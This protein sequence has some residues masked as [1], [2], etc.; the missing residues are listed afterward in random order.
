MKATIGSWLFVAFHACFVFPAH[1]QTVPALQFREGSVLVTG[2]GSTTIPDEQ[3]KDLLR[4]FTHEAFVKRMNQPVAGTYT[5]LGDSLTFTPDFNFAAGETYHA[6]FG[7]LELSF[8]IPKPKTEPTII[9]AVHPQAEVLPENMLRMYIT[10][11]NAMM[12]GEAYEHITLFRENGTPVEKAF[13]IID[14]ELWDAERKRFTLLF[15]PGRVKRGIRSNVE[16]GAPLQSGQAY[17]LVIDNTWL[18]AHGNLLADSYTKTFTVTCAQRTRLNLDHWKITP[19]EAGTRNDLL[20]EFDRPIDNALA[21]KFITITGTQGE[22]K[23]NATLT[24]SNLWRFT[25]DQPWPED[26]YHV[27]V[28]P[29]LEDVAGN[30]FNNVFDIDLSKENRVHSTEPLKYPFSIKTI[31]K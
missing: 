31:V 25:P 21:T 22:V 28:D 23:G 4:I 3:W 24:A 10:F 19:P 20:I 2:L 30:N 6:I 7:K 15:D 29:R 9:K 16:L 13:L 8:T 18:D 11:S 27:L 17:R 1:S 14:Q 26:Q 12:P 5:R